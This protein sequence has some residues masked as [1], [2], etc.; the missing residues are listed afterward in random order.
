MLL[1]LIEVDW[2]FHAHF[3]LQHEKAGGGGGGGGGGGY[4]QIL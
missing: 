1:P 3:P 2:D 4:N